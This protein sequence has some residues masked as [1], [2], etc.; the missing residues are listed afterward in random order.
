MLSVELAKV[1]SNLTA[2]TVTYN[3]NGGTLDGKSGEIIVKSYIGK[4]IALLGAPE[5]DGAEF[6]GW[7]VQNVKAD[8]AAFVTPDEN[9][10]VQAAGAKI[11]V[12]S[13]NVTVTAI[14]KK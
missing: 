2:A 6:V 13:A 1:A 10:A 8:D 14:W 4:T 9:S 5:M 7:N 12:E 11:T 3:L